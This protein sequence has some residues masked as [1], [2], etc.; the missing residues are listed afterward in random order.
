MS[1]LQMIKPS[2]NVVV[3]RVSAQVYQWMI[4]IGT[5]LDAAI[6]NIALLLPNSVAQVVYAQLAASNTFAAGTFPVTTPI[7]TTTVNG[8]LEVYWSGSCTG[9]TASTFY[10]FWLEIDG[11]TVQASR[12]TLDAASAN[13]AYS[14][15]GQFRVTG[16]APGVHTIRINAQPGG[17]STVTFTLPGSDH[18]SILIHEVR[19]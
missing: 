10:A 8:T 16:V 3:R 19:P 1:F 14:F 11:V 9:N 5:A 12:F 4:A 13:F 7:T 18:C 15:G 6:A 17:G 2:N